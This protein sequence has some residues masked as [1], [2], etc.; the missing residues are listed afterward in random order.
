MI[1]IIYASQTRNLECNVLFSCASAVHHLLG[2]MYVSSCEQECHDQLSVM[3]CPWSVMP[4]LTSRPMG[5]LQER[6]AGGVGGSSTGQQM[7]T[8]RQMAR[9]TLGR[10]G[11]AAVSIVYLALSFSLLTAYIAK[12]HPSHPSFHRRHTSMRSDKR[13]RTST[14]IRM[15]PVHAI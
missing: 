7:V 2:N 13:S 14:A 10:G 11:G 1:I 5:P 15:R 8:L 6:S 4:P 3:V 12:A 9:A